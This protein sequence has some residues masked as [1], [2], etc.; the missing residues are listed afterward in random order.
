MN[1]T[2]DGDLC[3][4]PP[5]L[6]GSSAAVRVAGRCSDKPPHRHNIPQEESSV[7][8]CSPTRLATPSHTVTKQQVSQEQNV[9]RILHH[10]I[11]GM[12][13]KQDNLGIL[14]SEQ[15]SE[16][17]VICITEHWFTKGQEHSAIIPDYH[18]AALFCREDHIRGGV[19]IF[20]KPSIQADTLVLTVKSREI[21]FEHAAVICRQIGIIVVAIYRSPSGNF[22]GF[23]EGFFNL[24]DELSSLFPRYRVFICGD[25]NIHFE[26]ENPV[27]TAF[28]RLC[29]CFQ[30]TA[31]IDSTTRIKN[32]PPSI[33]DNFLVK[34]KDEILEII[35]N[36][37]GLGSDHS[38]QLISLYCGRR[39]DSRLSK[40]IRIYSERNGNRFTNLLRNVN[41]NPIYIEND[42]NSAF[43]MFHS[44]LGGCFTQAFQSKKVGLHRSDRGWLTGGI[45]ISCRNK[46]SLILL[47]NHFHTSTFL[48]DRVRVY[49]RVLRGIIHAAKNKY[50]QTKIN[51]SSNKIK[52]TWDAIKCNIQR[53]PPKTNGNIELNLNNV[54]LTNPSLVANSFV[55][56]FASVPQRLTANLENTVYFYDYLRNVPATHLHCFKFFEISEKNLIHTVQKLKPK[57]STGYDDIP[58]TVIKQNIHYLKQPFTYL[59]NMSLKKGVFPDCY[60][61]AKIKPLF[62]KGEKN[63]PENY[64]PV[65][66]LPCMSKIL[67]SVVKNQVTV[68][69]AENSIISENQYGFQKNLNTTEAI[70]N[71]V[72]NVN[73]ILDD[74]SHPLAIFCD[75]SKAFDCVDHCVLIEKLDYYGISGIS[76]RW[77]TSYLKDRK[78]YVE[79]EHLE[80]DTLENISSSTRTINCGV[81]QGSILGPVLFLIYINDLADNFP[82]LKFTIFADDTNFLLNKK[83]LVDL[84]IDGADILDRIYKWFTANK[85]VLNVDKTFSVL[86]QPN[87]KVGDINIPTTGGEVRSQEN[88]RFLGVHID[89]SL[90]W[91]HHVE[92]LNK[93]LCSA[94][95]AIKTTRLNIGR[96]VAVTVYYAY[97]YSLLQYGIEFWGVS[98]DAGSAFLLQK[99]AIRAIFSIPQRRSCRDYFRAHKMFTLTNLY[100]YRTAVLM[101]KKRNDFQMQSDIHHHNTRNNSAIITPRFDLEVNR[102]CPTYMGIKIL[103][104]L[105]VSLLQT[106]D[107]WNFRIKLKELL[108]N[109]VFYN[110][111]EF[112]DTT[113]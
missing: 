91:K 71:L 83:S 105:P 24:N 47:A 40:T 56:Y 15:S 54:M 11:Q 74:K 110:I 18:Q 36:D 57:R 23:L 45:K 65:S 55:D 80:R 26:N 2:Q 67:E 20:T 82:E 99:R 5:K 100:I 111:N 61:I 66:L 81:P 95:Y 33:L 89:Q 102:K 88:V 52:A 64:R 31:I 97:F 10:N 46:R 30:L 70:H 58:I 96:D 87:K 98:V 78:F 79:L 35:N 84:R 29:D 16:V 50:F 19:M 41:W 77:F 48:R 9:L 69:A 85:L 101:N 51:S 113:F 8:T 73:H 53:I 109:H 21:D 92:C 60:K 22:D 63:L 107:K 94:I 38:A 59:V 43:N 76:N 93:S 3:T 90:S 104:H 25:F 28:G 62:K 6:Q 75:L 108:Q 68:Y 1:L 106:R 4:V 44:I 12:V 14:L 103:N 49:S 72:K 42:V 112:F 7:I 37:L 13:T 39:V 27:K 32:G 86:F 17:H 34:N